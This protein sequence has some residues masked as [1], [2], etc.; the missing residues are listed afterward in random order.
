VEIQGIHFLDLSFCW[1]AFASILFFKV[2][3]RVIVSEHRRLGFR[4]IYWR[5][6]TIAG[7]I[8]LAAIVGFFIPCELEALVVL[9]AIS[10]FLITAVFIHAR[11]LFEKA[12][13]GLIRKTYLSGRNGSNEAQQL[14]TLFPVL[15]KLGRGIAYGK[16]GDGSNRL[17]R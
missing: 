9:Y 3:R 7:E 12:H 1:I 13:T 2:G 11:S 5:G 16:K 17:D 4:E 8:A 6:E 14:E 10:A 15:G